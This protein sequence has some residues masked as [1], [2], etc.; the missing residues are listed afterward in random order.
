MSINSWKGFAFEVI[1]ASLGFMKPRILF[2]CT[3]NT[4]RSPM[5]EGLMR[6]YLKESKIEAEVLSAGLSAFEGSP[7]SENSV[8]A[9]QEKGIDIREQQS[10]QLSGSLVDEVTH[11][12][13][14][15]S[16]HL[17]VIQEY[18]PQAVE[19][20]FLVREF[21]AQDE[22]DR[23]IGDPFGGPLEQYQETRDQIDQ[24]MPSIMAF[25]KTGDPD[26]EL[27]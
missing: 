1:T 15:G 11:I 10:T 2:V 8:K 27:S 7:P 14:L 9:M 24:A 16:G 6:H 21:I 26:A 5:A 3:G 18:F 4:C 22:A 25:V 19:K 12:F 13:A 23:E 20:T 17:Q